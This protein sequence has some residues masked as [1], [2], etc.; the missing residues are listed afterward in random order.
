MTRSVNTMMLKPYEYGTFMFVS[1]LSMTFRNASNESAKI[2]M[3]P[4][5]FCGASA[6][7]SIAPASTAAETSAST[8]SDLE[9]NESTNESKETT[10]VPSTT[11]AA[12]RSDNAPDT[13]AGIAA[14]FTLYT[15]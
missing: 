13:C 12:A 8:K 4:P 6:A 15:D 1:T 10:C 11:A 5:D 3:K 9:T 14:H 2:D 7:A